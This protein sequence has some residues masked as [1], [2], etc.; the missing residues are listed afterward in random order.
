MSEG[1]IAMTN[2]I[3]V[4]LTATGSPGGVPLI[5]ALQREGV[6]VVA[7]DARP[8]VPALQFADAFYTLPP[9]KADGYIAVV[10][11]IVEEE[12]A[13]LVLPAS[14]AETLVLAQS[15][16]QIPAAVVLTGSP[17]S[18]KVCLDKWDT[19]AA[20]Q[21]LVPIPE[22][23]LCHTADQTLSALYAF[24]AQFNVV[25][26]K[27]PTGAG[28]RGYHLIVPDFDRL[29]DGWR[30]WPRPATFTFREV[31]EALERGKV[32]LPV[33]VMEYLPGDV[34][35]SVDVYC[36]GGEVLA[37]F[38]HDRYRCE[39]GLCKRHVAVE[40]AD[41]WRWTV[42]I[43][44]KL[45]WDGFLNAQ[46]KAGKLLEVN[47]R[48]STMIYSPTFNLPLL[49]IRH[50]LGLATEAELRAARLE[51]GRWMEYYTDAIGGC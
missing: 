16:D 12:S 2:A 32:K 34:E 24:E 45:E 38:V 18:V 27:Q 39:F 46:F 6:R 31:R 28:S 17:R 33:M 5:R 21:H 43:A 22:C 9:A 20:V 35:P 13:N 50:A 19:Y 25:V 1:A 48:I 51:P 3:T 49:G 8:D 4:L 7:T 26:L 47:P 36:A 37:G 44:R 23:I 30:D 40:R 14:N 11:D 41:E 29:S 42:A 15:K 10:K